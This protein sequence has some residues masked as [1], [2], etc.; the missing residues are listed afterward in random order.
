MNTTTPYAVFHAAQ[1][2][3]EWVATCE[4]LPG[5][6]CFGESLDETR[7][8]SEWALRDRV[9]ADVRLCH[10]VVPEANRTVRFA[11]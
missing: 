3:G 11:A 8:R 1:P 4:Q 5:W 2:S 6:F 7:A 9:V 10:Y